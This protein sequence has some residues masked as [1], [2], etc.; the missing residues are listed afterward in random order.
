[1]VFLSWFVTSGGTWADEK[2]LSVR[3]SLMLLTS[4]NPSDSLRR[5]FF[6]ATLVMLALLTFLRG[7]L[8]TISSGLSSFSSISSSNALN[9]SWTMAPKPAMK[10]R[11]L[12]LPLGQVA[13]SNHLRL[14]GKVRKS[15]NLSTSPSALRSAAQV[16]LDVQQAGNTSER[17]SCA[18]VTQKLD[19]SRTAVRHSVSSTPAP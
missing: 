12:P 3:I 11:H 6:S 19:L 7:R 4:E 13:A 16:L 17:E 5:S 10:R 14:S 18:K 2:V 15:G 9:F 1:M 8:C